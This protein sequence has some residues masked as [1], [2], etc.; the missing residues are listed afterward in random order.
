[1]LADNNAITSIIN[2]E[3]LQKQSWNQ[4]L[5]D[6]ARN[7]LPS[8]YNRVNPNN[9]VIVVE[10]QLFLVNMIGWIGNYQACYPMCDWWGD[11]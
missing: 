4:M 3:N 8:I 9:F 10:Y 11:W 6:Y 7:H 1:M 2:L 5:R